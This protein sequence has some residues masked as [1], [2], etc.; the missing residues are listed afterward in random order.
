MQQSKRTESYALRVTPDMMAFIKS[1]CDKNH[2]TIIGQIT[3]MLEMACK[4]I[5]ESNNGR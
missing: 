4:Q 1:E 5:K 2:R 3:L